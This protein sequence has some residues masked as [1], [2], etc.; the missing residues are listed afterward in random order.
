MHMKDSIFNYLL[1]CMLKTIIVKPPSL[2]SSGAPIAIP[3]ESPSLY[4]TGSSSTNPTVQY[5]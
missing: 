5:Q 3:I 4:P 2:Y 1:I